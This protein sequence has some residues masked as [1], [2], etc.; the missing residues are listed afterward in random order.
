MKNPDKSPS[1][2][3]IAKKAGVSPAA[4]SLAMRNA[5]RISKPVRE[6]IQKIAKEMGHKPN[7]YLA[8]YQSFVRTR[9]QPQFQA[10]IGWLNDHPEEDFWKQAYCQPMV[11]AARERSE[12]LGYRLDEIWV[13]NLEGNPPE[14]NESKWKR[15]ML[16]RGIRGVILPWLDRAEHAVLPWHDFSVACIG[17][18]R[19]LLNGSHKPQ[20][21]TC[22]HHQVNPLLF[23]NMV[24]ALEQLRIS[25]CRRIGLALSVWAD[26]ESDETYSA[27]FLRESSKRPLRERVPILFSDR[28]ED[29]AKWVRKTKPD[30]VVCGHPEVRGGLER[31]GLRIPHDIR[32]VHLNIA[33]DVVGW[34]GIDQRQELIGSAVVDVV[35]AHL[36][37]NECG[38]PP[39]PKEMFIE[40]V[41]VEGKT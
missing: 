34:S 16:A 33:P 20:Q 31:A 35:T 26:R 15:L 36:S 1:L 23:S 17:R 10:T 19:S 29:V 14:D 28:A 37:R 3:E 21:T 7:P 18:H 40:G 38:A 27:A 13:P 24:R 2:R 5:P 30:A 9:R 8:A 12:S 6:K 39:Y 41:W 22:E 4:V 32:L 25:G 11:R